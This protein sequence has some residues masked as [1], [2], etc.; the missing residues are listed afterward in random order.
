MDMNEQS[1]QELLD[2]VADTLNVARGI[3]TLDAG[4][5]VLP[6]WDSFSHLHLVVAIEAKYG[7]CFGADRIADM[8]SVRD[9]IVAL[10][11]KGVALKEIQS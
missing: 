6:Q 10:R 1:E 2:L 11:E 7:V 5:V 3:V 4:P 9:I 8:M